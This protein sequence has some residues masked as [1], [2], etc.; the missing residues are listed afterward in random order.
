MWRISHSHGLDTPQTVLIFPAEIRDD[1]AAERARARAR[2]TGA[3]SPRRGLIYYTV[4]GRTAHAVAYLE[5][6][7]YPP[8]VHDAS[9]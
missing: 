4:I 5:N 8:H 2:Y 1:I 7:R 6:R 9:A 3:M